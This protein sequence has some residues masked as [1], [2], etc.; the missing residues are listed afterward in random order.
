MTDY[1]TAVALALTHRSP[2]KAHSSDSTAVVLA[3]VY[4]PIQHLQTIFHAFTQQNRMSSPQ[5]PP[6]PYNY[7]QPNKIKLSPK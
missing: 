4:A 1:Q 3:F 7:N 5:T 6:K 2:L